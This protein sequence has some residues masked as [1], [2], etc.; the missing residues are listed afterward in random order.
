MQTNTQFNEVIQWACSPRGG[1]N[2]YGRLLNGCGRRAAKGLGT[3]GVGIENNKYMLYYD[4][5]WFSTIDQAMQ[6]VVIVHEAGHLALTHIERMLRLS[7]SMPKEKFRHLQPVFNV[8]ADMAVNSLAVEPFVLQ[9]KNFEGC[10]EKLVMPQDRNYP[11]QLSFEEYLDLL[12]EDL[13]QHGFDPNAYKNP[14]QVQ[15]TSEG[16][17]IDGQ[18]LAG[19]GEGEEGEEGEGSGRGKGEE[20]S[21]GEGS[22]G[23]P[24]PQQPEKQEQS[25]DGYP[26]WFKSL[27]EKPV[28]MH[29]D[30]SKVVENMTESEKE[31]AA[32]GLKQDIKRIVK[33]AVS[34]TKKS[35]G[36]VPGHL[37]SYLDDL[38]EEHQVPWEVILRNMVKSVISP[39][40]TDSV[41]LPNIGML[42]TMEEEGGL[43]PYPGFQ[44]DFGFHIAVA[45]DTSGSVGDHEFKLM[46][47][48]LLGIIKVNKSISLQIIYFDCHIQKEVLIT[49]DDASDY[50]A[51]RNQLRNRYGHGGTDFNAAFKR[52]LQKDDESCWDDDA[53]RE[54]KQMPKPDLAIV[55]TDGYAPVES[56]SGPIPNL[57]PPYPTL[58]VITPDGK[59]DPAMGDRAIQM[60]ESDGG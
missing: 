8:A 43:E 17:S 7:S 34:Q 23:G 10:I 30:M 45:V 24:P 20:G 11:K 32:S 25:A 6:I 47:Q 15:I 33:T 57:V 48:E 49:A 18:P 60:V 51:I 3:M 46:M 1:N 54:R 58:W 21:E 5:D 16:V 56:P 55:F 12:L 31:R 38:M 14:T 42:A 28:Q 22:G 39:S 41:V 59:T 36:T 26:G 9:N 52:F 2:F 27:L 29:I 4:L 40:M 35:R 44:R 37:Q 50:N 13:D 19:S 53:Y